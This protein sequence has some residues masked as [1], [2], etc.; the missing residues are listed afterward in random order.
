MENS[1]EHIEMHLPMTLACATSA[2]IAF[3]CRA[4]FEF[5]FSKSRLKEHPG[6]FLC[7]DGK[8]LRVAIE[9]AQKFYA[10][11]EEVRCSSRKY[12]CGAEGGI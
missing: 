12:S 6:S 10:W 5:P 7:V 1:V 3:V 9:L 2:D 8:K 4:S 11:I